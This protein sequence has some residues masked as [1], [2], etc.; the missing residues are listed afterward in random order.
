M[1]FQ[2]IRHPTNPLEPEYILPYAEIR[3]PTPPKFIR[4]NIDVSDIPGTTP[5][6][7]NLRNLKKN[8]IAQEDVEGSHVRKLYIPKDQIDIMNVKDINEF[9]KF[10]TNRL[11]NP[12]N[13]E[14]I[15]SDGRTIGKIDHNESRRLHP[16][17]VH[18]E[19]NYSLRTRDI[20]GCYAD[21]LQNK[22]NTLGKLGRKNYRDIN[23]THDVFGA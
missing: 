4:D 6:P 15:V 19:V 7:Y 3:I 10:K 11:V 22:F 16:I 8:P 13:P 23:Q 14:Y 18:K 17:E 20:D 12:L 21:T 9:L 5:H 2:T 1:K